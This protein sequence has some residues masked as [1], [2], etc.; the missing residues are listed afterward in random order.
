MSF[1]E[2]LREEKVKEQQL[3]EEVRLLEV[4]LAAVQAT[5][6]R[7]QG[8]VQMLERI[9][10]ESIV[11]S[12]FIQSSSGNSSVQNNSRAKRSTKQDME[13]RR[14]VVIQVLQEKGPSTAKEMLQHV[15][16]QLGDNLKIHHLR[17]VLQKFD[18]S[19]DRGDEHGVW[20]LKTQDLSSY[21]APGVDVPEPSEDSTTS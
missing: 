3:Q 1:E 14:N 2:Q 15:N 7:Q 10:A 4:Q 8:A 16:A 18:S 20:R 12:G 5:L 11:G 17:N 13:S 6:L 19:F 9:T 21:G